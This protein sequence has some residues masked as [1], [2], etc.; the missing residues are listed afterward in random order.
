MASDHADAGDGFL[1]VMLAEMRY[2]IITGRHSSSDSVES[3]GR[4]QGS[5]SLRKFL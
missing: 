3:K 2:F 1:N 4:E 5:C